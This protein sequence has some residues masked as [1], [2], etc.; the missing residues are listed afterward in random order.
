MN[1]AIILVIEDEV[2]LQKMLRITLESNDYKV[3]LAGNGKEGMVLAANYT[4]D[5]I[6]LDLGLP[7]VSGA[8]VLVRLREWYDRGIIILTAQNDEETTVKCLDLGASDFLNKPYRSAELMARIR[9]VLRRNQVSSIE[10]V[11]QFDKL[12]LNLTERAVYKN[13]LQLKLTATEYNLLL[14]LAQNE[15]RV[16]T[17][18]Y[19]L[20]EI[21]GVGQQEE[22]QYLRVFIAALRKKI[23]DNPNN[24]SHILT[25]SGVGYRFR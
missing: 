24:P 4:P 22:T 19:L 5:I 16:L 17:H 25:E 13:D 18:R 1:K 15:G 12:Q 6:L 8:D 21:W 23:E 14:L 10:T 9:A 20:K 7:D 11:L 2:Q 3:L